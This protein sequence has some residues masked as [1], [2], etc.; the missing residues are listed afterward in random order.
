MKLKHLLIS[1]LIFALLMP[2]FTVFPSAQGEN[3]M[4]IQG[5]NTLRKTDSAVI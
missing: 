1:V 5:E 3:W 2:I 4:F